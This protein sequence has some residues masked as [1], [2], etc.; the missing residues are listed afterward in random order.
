M[1]DNAELGTYCTVIEQLT[2]KFFKVQLIKVYDCNWLSSFISISDSDFL[3]NS[4]SFD[5]D[6]TTAE[7]DGGAIE[8]VGSI[9]TGDC[10]SINIANSSSFGSG[11]DSP[12]GG[13]R[14]LDFATFRQTSIHSNDGETA[15]NQTMDDIDTQKLIEMLQQN[16]LNELQRTSMET[17]TGY[18]LFTP[19][20][21]Q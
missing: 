11:S 9:G 18:G 3:F 13:A 7:A 2:S 6:S 12:G 1:D 8:I 20:Q 19:S 15:G 14:D 4:V 17:P 16:N 10:M 5:N 21:M